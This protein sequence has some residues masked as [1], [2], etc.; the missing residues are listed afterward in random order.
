MSPPPE[1]KRPRRDD[2]FDEHAAE[3]RWPVRVYYEDT[4]AGGIVYHA[5]WLRFFERA[6]TEW[7]RSLGAGHGEIE[8]ESGALFVVRDLAVD[9][10]APARLDDELD[11]SLA[12]AALRGASLSLRQVARHRGAHAVLVEARV[13]VAMVRRA[14]GRPVP[15]PGWLAQRITGCRP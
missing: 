12:I 7:L 10:R 4:D 5:N 14:D 2:R 8:R 6:R 1:P 9:Y 13:R 11:L 15:L 3:F